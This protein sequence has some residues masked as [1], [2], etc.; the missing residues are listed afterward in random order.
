MA[1]YKRDAKKMLEEAGYWY[2]GGALMK[3]PDSKGR[4]RTTPTQAHSS[5]SMP[6]EGATPLLNGSA[7]APA[8]IP[9]SMRAA[10]H[11]RASGKQAMEV[12]VCARV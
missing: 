4:H 8:E 3:K 2:Q 12:C 1:Q 10:A 11:A 9:V 6:G 5:P 7:S